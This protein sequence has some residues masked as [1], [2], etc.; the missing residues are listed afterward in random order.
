MLNILFLTTARIRDLDSYG[1]YPDLIR[2]FC[3]E[4]HRVTVVSPLQRREKGK[5]S[6]EEFG[7][8]RVLKVKTLNI[9]RTNI[10]EKIVSTLT[11]ERLYRRAI[12]KYLSNFKFDVILYSTPPITFIKT[13]EYIKGR[14]NAFSYLLLKDIFPQNAVDMK[15][16]KDG[17]II[18]R[19]LL[20]KEKKLYQISDSIGC[21]SEA[22]VEYVLKNNPE[23]NPNKVEVNPNSITPNYICYKASEKARIR[24]KY[25]IPL[26]KRVLVY[27]GNLG[28]PQ[29]LS[30][31]L[32]TI[33]LSCNEDAYFLIVGSGTEFNR[34]KRWFIRCNPHNARL[35]TRLPKDDYHRL[36]AA[37]DIGLIFLD[38]KFS[39]PNFPSRLLS[40]LEMQKPII[41][42][43]D[44]NTDIGD[45]IERSGCG[46]KVM[47]GDTQ[48]MNEVISRMMR[49]DL[50]IYAKS[51]K[52]LLEEEYLVD[53]S[54]NIIVEKLS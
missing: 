16:L 17:G 21:M 11:I 28:K 5:T 30:F 48:K 39:I 38:E 53:I 41:A 4:G 14:D 44:K 47:A 13:I 12:I 8:F 35:L 26:D 9:T 6:Y 42:A 54:Y 19:H 51:C 34:L 7:N 1:I 22:N 15:M 24:E 18:H 36:L 40:Y 32:T 37:C 31:L 23:I 27:G 52:E 45:V 25:G 2:K 43:T 33:L 50:S 29:G 3:D 20:K 46:Y 49:E 10:L